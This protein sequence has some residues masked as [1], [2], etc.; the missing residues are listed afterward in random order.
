MVTP[1]G[2]TKFAMGLETFSSS[3]TCFRVTGKVAAL[4]LD[5]G[6][7]PSGIV[8]HDGFPRCPFRYEGPGGTYKCS[9]TNLDVDQEMCNRCDSETRE[10]ESNIGQKMVNYFGAVRRWVANG[11]PSRTDEQIIELFETHCQQ[12]ERYD[13]KKHA[14][15]NCGCKVSNDSSPLT[16]KL[17]MLT[18][19]C[20][21]GRW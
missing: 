9:M 7:V 2:K 5:A 18:E 8:A 21:L 11:R 4:E 3:V 1:T 19:H 15:K 16:N 14:C 6:L 10:H 13:E 20:P 17:G 12:C